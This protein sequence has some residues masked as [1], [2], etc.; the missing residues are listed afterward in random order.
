L[1]LSAVVP[2]AA[3]RPFTV[4]PHGHGALAVAHIISPC[5]WLASPSSQLHLGSNH[6]QFRGRELISEI[7]R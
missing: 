5:L 7:R 1:H 2:P 3:R 4:R 6:T